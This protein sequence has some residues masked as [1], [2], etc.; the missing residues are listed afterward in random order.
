MPLSIDAR[1]RDAQPDL[2]A[3]GMS[4]QTR[5]LRRQDDSFARVAVHMVRGRW[6]GWETYSDDEFEV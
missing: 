4:S 1:S 3:R 2:V 6:L 5:L